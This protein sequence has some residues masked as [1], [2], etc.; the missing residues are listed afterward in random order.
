MIREISSAYPRRGEAKPPLFAVARSR[1]VVPSPDAAWG[2]LS[3]Q[4]EDRCSS[5][6]RSEDRL[7]FLAARTLTRGLLCLW[8]TRVSDFAAWTFVQRCSR[9]G[10][11]H[12]RPSVLGRGD[13]WV[14]WAHTNGHVCAVVGAQHV[15]IDIERVSVDELPLPPGAV[16]SSSG[17][18]PER[19]LRWTRAEALVKCLGIDLEEALRLSLDGPPCP[20]GR[21]LRQMAPDVIS[22]V[23][24]TDAQDQQ[25]AWVVSVASNTL[26]ERIH[27]PAA[28]ARDHGGH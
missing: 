26:P 8:D 18:D 3:A 25:D 20:E 23:V 13:L 10:G 24:L 9:C 17:A 4:E 16:P 21:P 2:R 7:G 12:G 6:R 27:D 22:D 19:W 28:P 5:L 1:D 11:P 14:S 15:G